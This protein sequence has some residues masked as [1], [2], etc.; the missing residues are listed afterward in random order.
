LQKSSTVT[1][2]LERGFPAQKGSPCFVAKPSDT[3]KIVYGFAIR[4]QS[5]SCEDGAAGLPTDAPSWAWSFLGLHSGH[6]PCWNELFIWKI[7]SFSGE[8][9]TV[10]YYQSMA[11]MEDKLHFEKVLF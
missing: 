6:Y 4:M 7:Y 11:K 1:A 8:R 2:L 10:N 9:L 3:G 5:G